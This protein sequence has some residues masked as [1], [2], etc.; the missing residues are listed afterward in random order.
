MISRALI[1]VNKFNDMIKSMTGY[2]K[3]QIDLNNKSISIEI[4]SLNSKQLDINLRTPQLF[5]EKEMEIRS[6]LG[7]VLERGKIDATISIDSKTDSP[8]VSINQPLALQYYQQLKS[9][10]ELIP[11]ASMD[12]IVSILVKLPDVFKIEKEEIIESEWEQINQGIRQAIADL[13]EFRRIEGV[14]LEKDFTFRV[15]K[16]LTHLVS[17]EPFEG[18]RVAAFRARLKAHLEELNPE[19]TYDNNRL[20]QELVYYFEKLD[21]TEEKIRL[22]KHIDYFIATLK[23]NDSPGK[24]L[25]FISQEI[26]R[27]INTLGS[28]ANDAEIQKI[29]VQM[30]DELE[31]IKEQLANIL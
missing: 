3:C 14:E 16:I 26:G 21:I 12:D 19:M 13:E 15:N 28:K 10:A 24:K 20:E 1:F 6:L 7:Q 31:K 17:I 27:E 2:G 11:E 29:V 23:D 8:V 5:R 9:L 22:K 4:R 18:E 25:G 30:K